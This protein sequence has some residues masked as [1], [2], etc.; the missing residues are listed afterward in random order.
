M[1]QVGLEYGMFSDDSCWDES[2]DI[3]MTNE[4]SVL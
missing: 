3:C 1:V 4:L 2:L